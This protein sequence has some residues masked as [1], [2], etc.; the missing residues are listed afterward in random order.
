[1][2]QFAKK[3]SFLYQGKKLSQP[4]DNPAICVN[5]SIVTKNKK[6]NNMDLSQAKYFVCYKKG[7]YVNKC[8][9]K[10]P[11]TSIGTSNLYVDN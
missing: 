5:T 11:K 1:M 8:S 9:N 6:Q 7:H 2:G 3:S 10:K 4:F